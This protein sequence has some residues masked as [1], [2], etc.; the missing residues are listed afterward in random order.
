MNIKNLTIKLIVSAIIFLSACKKEESV[1]FIDNSINSSLFCGKSFKLTSVKWWFNTSPESKY[2]KL[3]S[4]SKDLDNTYIFNCDG[5]F[6]KQSGPEKFDE[7]DVDV[8]STWSLDNKNSR[9][10]TMPYHILKCTCDS[11]SLIMTAEHTI[12]YLDSTKLIIQY[13]NKGGSYNPSSTT[14]YTFMV[15]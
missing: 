10:I 11:L 9:K 2:E 7:W 1:E 14:E 6:K 4:F 15:K 3:N 12:T 5:T 13:L 8:K